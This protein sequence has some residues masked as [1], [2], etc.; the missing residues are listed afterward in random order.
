MLF[1]DVTSSCK[2]AMSTG[3]QR[4]VRS[5]HRTL[6]ARTP[7]EPLIW[8]DQLGSYCQLSARERAFLEDTGAST[9]TSTAEPE[10]AA[11][12][13]PWSKVQRHF[14][15]RLRRLDLAAHWQPGDTF[16]APEIFQDRRI[17][18]LAARPPDVPIRRVAFF[19]DAIVWR[20]PELCPPRRHAR[21]EEYMT[22]LAGFD[23][24]VTN[25]EQSAAD[26]R[27]FWRDSRLERVPP[28]SPHAL[29]ID[30]A[31]SIQPAIPAP[32]SRVVLCVATLEARKNHL[33]LLA[34]AEGL[35]NE[36]VVFELELIGRTTRHWGERVTAE[37]ERLQNAGRPVRWQM[38][39]DDRRLARAYEVCRF[40]VF[41]S[42][43]EGF[44]LPILESL[45]HGKPCICADRGAIAETAAGGGCRTIDV[46]R[47]DAIADAMR[48]LL[49]SDE[50]V[51]QLS[52]EAAAR[53][54]PTWE[55]YAGWLCPK[56]TA[57][58]PA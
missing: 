41:P 27:E 15:H 22:T 2:S 13:W 28:V 31:G 9:F 55:D 29:A 52:R 25:S 51:A 45:W 35:W 11:N 54:F 16:F 26:L 44:G 24:I 58:R 46:T 33:A 47:V 8:D 37:I 53:S 14:T 7:V 32:A 30:A 23:E 3:V 39:V 40:T 50:A 21:F 17:D 20:H 4:V 12:P 34:A 38:H 18:W 10:F 48:E 56:L 36:G 5:L 6:L 19:H 49:A 42:L 57:G 43:V 1:L